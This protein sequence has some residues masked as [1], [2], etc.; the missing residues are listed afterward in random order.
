MSRRV[1]RPEPDRLAGLPATL[2][3]R[4]SGKIQESDG[5]SLPNQV[6]RCHEVADELGVE[7]VGEDFEQGSGQDWDLKGMNRWLR[8]AKQ[9]SIK[10]L[11]L[12]NVSR[13][14]R[15]RAKQG[16]IEHL[17][18][19]HGLILHYYDEEYAPTAAGNLQRGIMSEVAEFMLEQSREDSM[20]ARYE[21]V[22]TYQRPV[23]N[24]PVPYGWKRIVDRSGAKPRTVG[25]E[26]HPE[27]AEVIRR[28][29]ALRTLSTR[30]LA[31]QLQAEGVPTPALYR[32]TEGRPLSGRWEPY[33]IRHI[34]QNKMVW[35]EYRYGERERYKVDGRWRQRMKPDAQVETLQFE[36]ILE[37]DEVEELRAIISRRRRPT[38]PTPDR[39]DPFVLRGMLVCGRCGSSLRTQLV[40]GG[41]RSGGTDRYYR[42]PLTNKRIALRQRREVCTLPPVSADRRRRGAEGEGIEELVWS[43][44]RRVFADDRTLVTMIAEAR[45]QDQRAEEHTA[46]LAWLRQTLVEKRAAH[47]RATDRWSTAEDELDRESFESTRARLSRDIRAFE[48]DLKRLEQVVPKGITESQEAAL[49]TL[50][51]AF[52]AVMARV[53][54]DD[55]RAFCVQLGLSVRVTP[56]DVGGFAVGRHRYEV[57][58]V[59]LGQTL[60]SSADDNLTWL[61]LQLLR[62]DT[63]PSLS[64]VG[65]SRSIPS[66]AAIASA[67]R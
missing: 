52:R 4:V 39:D 32:P 13:L 27:H 7:V 63:S 65:A 56:V 3:G 23:G 42:C 33:V 8:A 28:F 18:A 34:L 53:T 14:S 29:R 49:L 25:Y 10:V 45:K 1:S 44:V 43:A 9:G 60:R 57:E 36:P 46:S 24:G 6:R 40:G 26:H 58:G 2:W 15:S 47:Q 51:R 22:V 48:V 12:K 31:D 55:R 67:S 19:E 16:W 20:A 11:I 54:T 66:L 5:Y 62:S 61:S 35:G 21:K 37:R 17:A 59:A 38:T 50:G 41:K 64:L 30:E